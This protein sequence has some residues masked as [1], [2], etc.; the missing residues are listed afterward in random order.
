MPSN[1]S[2]P[3]EH[4]P[5]R[6]KNIKTI[7]WDHRLL[8]IHTFSVIVL[9]TEE[10]TETQQVSHRPIKYQPRSW[11]QIG[12]KVNGSH[13]GDSPLCLD[14]Q[15]SKSRQNPCQVQP[16]ENIGNS[17]VSSSRRATRRQVMQHFT[18]IGAEHSVETVHQTFLLRIESSLDRVG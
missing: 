18:I 7:R 17:W 2:R 3:S 5:V 4:P 10:T 9:E 8:S 14:Q 6:G 11:S 15:G 16:T 13:H 1:A 12:T